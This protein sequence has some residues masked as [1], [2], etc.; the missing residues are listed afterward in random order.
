MAILKKERR[1]ETRYFFST[2]LKYRLFP[3]CTGICHPCHTMNVST[4]GLCILTN[5]PLQVGHEIMIEECL[6]PFSVDRAIVR[7][8]GDLEQPAPYDYMA[9][10]E[11][12]KFS[13]S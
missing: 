7:W 3:E 9:G 4:T 8:V 1:A 11:F 2:F 13:S 6:L 5:Y 12:Q 10:V